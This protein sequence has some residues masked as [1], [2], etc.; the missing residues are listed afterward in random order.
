MVSEELE[1]PWLRLHTLSLAVNLLPQAWRTLRGSWPL[2]LALVVGGG[3]LGMQV[4]DLGLIFFFFALTMVNTVM[5]RFTLR[6]RVNDGRLEIKSGLLNRRRRALDPARIQNIE[7]VRNVFHRVSGLVEVRIETAGDASTEGLLS[8]LGEEQAAALQAEIQELV[9]RAA[10]TEEDEQEL[11]DKPAIAEMGLAEIL[12]YGLSSRSLG[13]VAVMT[14]VGLEVFGRMG[15]EASQ[16]LAWLSQ[17]RILLASFVLAFAASYIFS[18]GN[19]LVRHFRYRLVEDGDRLVTTEGLTTTRR[20][21]IPLRKVQ[22]VRADEPL[23]RRLMGYGT[24]LIETAGLGITEGQ[25]RQAEGMVPMAAKDDLP[26]V[27]R[28]AIPV[29]EVDPWTAELKPAHPRALLRAVSARLIRSTLLAVALVAFMRPWGWGALLL[30]PLSIPV[31]WLDWRFQAWLVTERVVVARRGFFNRQT[32]L[33]SR[34][35]VQSVHLSQT[36]FMR[37]HKLG[38]VVVRVAG[39]SVSLPDIHIDVARQV[40]DELSPVGRPKPELP[41]ASL[42]EDTLPSED[43]FILE[44]GPTERFRPPSSAEEETDREDAGEDTGDI[45]GEAGEDPMAELRDPHAAE[46]HG[47]HV[48]G[49][50][51]AAVHGA[52]QVADVA[53]G[54]VGLDEIGGDAEGT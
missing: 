13:A 40:L 52:D 16:E 24:V 10:R 43:E 15:P 36:P 17:P 18:A 23:M 26:W 35:K 1:T 39:S 31:A 9:G 27:F 41:D 21:E 45:C 14:A 28:H 34:E 46:V 37:W 44:D 29:A 6:Y 25:V 19:S 51:G 4:V 42:S 3:G 8:A 50:L 54:A 38:R 2:L 7:L 49:G 33:I 22:L 32:F 30:I 12:A 11:A 47:E 5:H 53:V 20:V 48:E